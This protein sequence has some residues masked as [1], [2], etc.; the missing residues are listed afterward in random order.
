M[1]LITNDINDI[2]KV[3]NSLIRLQGYY[4]IRTTIEL[5]NLTSNAEELITLLKETYLE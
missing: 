2:D 1:R 4:D 3:I 5:P